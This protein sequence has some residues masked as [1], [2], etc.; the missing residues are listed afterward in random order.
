MNNYSLTAKNICGD[1]MYASLK[2]NLDR[3]KNDYSNSADLTIR[4]FYLQSEPKTKA[5]IITL[6]GMSEKEELAIQVMNPIIAN[7]Y[8]NLSGKK[9]FDYIYTTVITVSEMK[10]CDTF[11]KSEEALMAGFAILFIDGSE[12]SAAIGVQSP[13]SRSVDEPE[14]EVVQRGSREGF[15]EKVRIN[16]P[17]I[18]KR[19]RNPDLVFELFTVGTISKTE[20]C[21]CY[22]KSAVSDGI[23]KALKKRLNDCDLSTVLASGYLVP[24]LEDNGSKSVFSGVGVSERPDTVCGK[25]SEGRIAVMIDGTPSVLLVPHL[26]SEDFQSIDDYS[27]RPYYAF[28]T[29]ILKYLSFIISL[30][31]PSLYVAFAAFH[32]DY[33]PTPLLKNIIS[34]VWETPLPLILEVLM[35]HFIYEVMREAGLRIP[36]PLGHAVGIVGG[37]VIGDSAVSAGIIGAPTLMVVALSAICGYVV[38][39]LN[40]AITIFRFA[41]IIIGG[42]LGVWGIALATCILLVNMC[43]KTSFGVPYMAPLAPFSLFAM[44]DTFVRRGWKTL[45][46]KQNNVQNMPGTG[47][48]YDN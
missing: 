30:Y 6:E 9:L 47:D 33:F 16:M 4:E 18:R 26:F 14:T 25:L 46:K 24:Y 3:I 39:T 1:F 36:R 12:I 43:G 22:L 20:V 42:V 10:T 13:P 5:A 15:V 35:L 34:A 8:G 11:E 37:L 45:S 7:V 29:R 28:F 40:P 2:D 23:L 32:P 38:P 44:R 21:I 27:N 17:L 19:M 31:L 41:L 48:V